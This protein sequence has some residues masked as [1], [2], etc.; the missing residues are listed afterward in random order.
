MKSMS[1]PGEATKVS[2]PFAIWSICS[3]VG[4]LSLLMRSISLS[5]V[6]HEVDQTTGVGAGAGAGAGAGT[7]AVTGLGFWTC[8]SQ[9]PS[10][11]ESQIWQSWG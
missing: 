5:Q 9:Q 10:P 8:F 7:E 1:R 2:Q 4:P 6:V 11:P 3:L